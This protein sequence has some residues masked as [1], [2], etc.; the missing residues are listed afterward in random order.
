MAT[1]FS[2]A[3]WP[4]RSTPPIAPAPS[5]RSIRYLPA[6]TRPIN[7]AST[8][9]VAPWLTTEATPFLR[10]S[11][12]EL[13]ADEPYL[14]PKSDPFPIFLGRWYCCHLLFLRRVA[15]RCQGPVRI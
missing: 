13:S 2:S 7:D 4:P 12:G 8:V 1:G 9:D 11:T 10:V 3:S 14:A 5:R 15:T 6:R